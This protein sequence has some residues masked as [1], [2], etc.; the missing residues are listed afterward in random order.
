[1]TATAFIKSFPLLSTLSP[2][3][4]CY[5]WSSAVPPLSGH[6]ADKT[7]VSVVAAGQQWKCTPCCLR[8][9]QCLTFLQPV[10]CCPPPLDACS[11]SLERCTTVLYCWSFLYQFKLHPTK[12]THKRTEP[13]LYSDVRACMRVLGHQT[14]LLANLSTNYSHTVV[15]E[16]HFP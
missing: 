10:W 8:Q 13:T 2:C 6:T 4:R 7:T 16:P 3:H 5:G 1:M 11:S 15:T 14:I 12:N 9:N